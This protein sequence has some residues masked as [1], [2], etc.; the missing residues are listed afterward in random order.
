MSIPIGPSGGAGTSPAPK[1][2]AGGDSGVEAGCLGA[3][4]AVGH[5]VPQP[6]EPLGVDGG[7]GRATSQGGD[8]RRG[9]RDDGDDADGDEPSAVGVHG[10][11]QPLLFR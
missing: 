2:A 4:L 10:S 5:R 7:A 3:R 6:R 9:R 11:R 8:D 1:K